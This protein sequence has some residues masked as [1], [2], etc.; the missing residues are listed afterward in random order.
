MKGLRG[1][2]IDADREGRLS[3]NRARPIPVAP[4]RLDGNRRLQQRSNRRGCSSM[5]EQKL[6]KLTTR[7]RFPSPA[8]ATSRPSSLIGGVPRPR[9]WTTCLTLP[10][11]ASVPRA[12]AGAS[13]AAA[14]SWLALRPPSHPAVRL[15]PGALRSPP[16]QGCAAP[17]AEPP[18]RP[19]CGGGFPAGFHGTP[20]G[21][22]PGRSARGSISSPRTIPPVSREVAEKE[23]IGHHGDEHRT[24]QGKLQPGTHLHGN[25]LRSRKRSLMP[26]TSPTAAMRIGSPA[27]SANR[28]SS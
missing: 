9:R 10:S 16:T 7:V 5:V 24:D 11:P 22:R 23:D 26:C 19:S 14:R 21:P 8:P 1:L 28:T 4:R 25:F 15:H 13:S 20:N 17:D 2:T 6:P 27:A 18:G 3:A 12:G